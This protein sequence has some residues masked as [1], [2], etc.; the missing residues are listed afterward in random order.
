[1]IRSKIKFKRLA[2]ILF[3][4]ANS[5]GLFSQEMIFQSPPGI[6]I[7][8]SASGNEKT[9]EYNKVS[10]QPDYSLPSEKEYPTTPQN[11]HFRRFNRVNPRV[12]NQIGISLDIGGPSYIGVSVDY[13]IIPELNLLV[14]GGMK[15]LHMGSKY[16]IMGYK[17]SLWTPFFGILGTI[18]FDDSFG[19]YIPGGFQYI[20]KYGFSIGFELAVWIKKISADPNN[21][22]NKHIEFLGWGALNI[23]YHF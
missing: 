7:S 9:S 1:M 19:V 20:G 3:L 8:D 2:L 17:S 10:Y 6:I 5:S 11:K 4:I 22:Q 15:G 18:S 21:V 14:G 13:F 23:G 12:I 16:H